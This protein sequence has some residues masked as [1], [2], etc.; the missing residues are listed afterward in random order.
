[1]T[2][3]KNH[4]FLFVFFDSVSLLIGEQQVSHFKG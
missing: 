4:T 1:M 2:L 3:G